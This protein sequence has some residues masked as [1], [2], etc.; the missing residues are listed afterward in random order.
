[1][2]L[3]ESGISHTQETEKRAL[4][5]PEPIV[6]P[7]SLTNKNAVVDAAIAYH[8]EVASY[9]KNDGSEAKGIQF[10]DSIARVIG[11]MSTERLEVLSDPL[12]NNRSKPSDEMNPAEAARIFSVR[13]AAIGIFE[14]H[15]VKLYPERFG[16]RPVSMERGQTYDVDS[17]S[18]TISKDSSEIPA[19]KRKRFAK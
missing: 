4:R 13:R 10:K 1:M 7:E 8:E 9:L 15:A 2:S 17:T 5:L 12:G 11:G 14:A 3:L 6:D 16:K 18:M 19:D